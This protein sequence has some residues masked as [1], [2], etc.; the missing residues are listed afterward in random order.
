MNQSCMIILN[1][2]REHKKMQE[3]TWKVSEDKRKEIIKSKD[4]AG[5]ETLI[6]SWLQ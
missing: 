6:P 4:K 3:A 2:D 5:A 1:V